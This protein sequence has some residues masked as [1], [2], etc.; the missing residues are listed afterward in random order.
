MLDSGNSD[1][2]P[3]LL[4]SQS[5]SAGSATQSGSVSSKLA[6]ARS[7]GTFLLLGMSSEP[8]VVHSPSK[9]KARAIK[10]LD[11]D[12]DGHEHN[13]RDGDEH[14]ALASV[15]TKWTTVLSWLN[16]D[17]QLQNVGSVARDHLANERTFLAWL[18]T[19]LSLASIGVGEFAYPASAPCRAD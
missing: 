2:E 13:G 17:L 16:Q 18:R 3:L 15:S 7:Y 8:A 19:S 11:D 9:G 14:N 1:V 5:A 12:N 6:A 10:R 4:S